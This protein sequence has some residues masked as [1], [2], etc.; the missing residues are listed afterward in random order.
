MNKF[1]GAIIA[2]LMILSPLSYANDAI[3]SP[4]LDNEAKGLKIA[5]E[6][7]SRDR[8]WGDVQSQLTMLLT[9]R[10]GRSSERTLTIKTLEVPGDGDKSLTLFETP[11][12]VKGTSFLS[13]SHPLEADQQWLYLPAL[14]RVKRISSSNKSGPF[15]GSE[16]SFEDLSSFEVEKY[17]YTYLRDEEENGNKFFIVKYIPLYPDSGYKFQE[18]WIDQLHYRI[19]KIVF[20]DR[21][22]A[23]LKTLEF[24]DYKKYLD[25]YW[26][27]D[28]YLVTNHQTGKSTKLHWKGYQFKSGLSDADFNQNKLKR[29]R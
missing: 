11:R 21:K 1:T 28:N 27:A 3:N 18:V 10:Q 7:E 26:R 19:H 6:L 17:S 29:G 14:K 23:L 4:T 2:S 24:N 22:G 13:F 12:D 20:H 8:G 5:K 9:D 25:T 15:L 16:F